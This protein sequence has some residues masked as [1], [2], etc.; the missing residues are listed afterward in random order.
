MRSVSEAERGAHT[1]SE[2]LNQPRA[3]VEVMA[4]VEAQARELRQLLRGVDEVVFTGCGS[5]LNVSYVLAPTFQHFTELKASAVPAAEVVFFSETVFAGDGDYLLVPISRSGE[6]T[7]TVKAC[8][9]AQSRGMRTLSITCR[10]HSWLA[11]QAT[12]SLI[13]EPA[14]ERSV[15]TTQS[16]TSMV[17]CGQVM[18]AILSGEAEYLAQLKTL[19]PQGRWVIERYGDLG[20]EIAQRE[21]ITRF[22]FVGSGPYW[23]LARECQ[24]K[25][26][27]MVL[28]PSDAYPLFDYRHGPKS[29]VDEHM[30]VTVLMSDRAQREEITFIKDMK[31][32]NGKVLA[33]CD[34]ADGEIEG[35]A[36][37]LVEV[38]S[39]LPEFARDILYMP[40]VHFLAYFKSLL[41]GQD[42]DHPA[43]LTYWVEL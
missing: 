3:W 2:I 37:Y 38:E 20:R 7:E 9:L 42:P 26:K 16:L 40:P 12:E 18:T 13:L 33:I 25:V 29:N 1:R 34:Q 27:E 30:L 43:N 35:I 10:R 41:R 11:Q 8:E 32:L 39:G 21:E 24:L 28:L 6:T 23:G 14:D 36:D 22:A 19:P 17:L 4:L 31:E 15:V 5:A